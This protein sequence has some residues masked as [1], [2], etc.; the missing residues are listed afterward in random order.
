MNKKCR[1]RMMAR[2]TADTDLWDFGA[3]LTII[4]D[5]NTVFSQPEA[6]LH[7]APCLIGLRVRW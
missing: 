6:T 5:V 2:V 7:K 4:I 1:E 3:V